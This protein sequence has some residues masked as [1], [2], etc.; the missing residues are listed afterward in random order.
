[1]VFV[2]LIFIFYFFRNTLDFSKK[3]KKTLDLIVIDL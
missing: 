2:L 3:K 1:M